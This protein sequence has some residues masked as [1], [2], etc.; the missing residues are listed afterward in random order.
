LCGFP[1]FVSHDNQQ[2]PLFDAILAGV[3][4]FPS[5]YWDEIGSASRDLI[6]NMLQNDPT[7]RFSSEDILDHYWLIID[8]DI[9][10]EV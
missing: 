4:D 7:V 9:G 10:G 1:P 3:F 5:P 8:N 6:I 2:E